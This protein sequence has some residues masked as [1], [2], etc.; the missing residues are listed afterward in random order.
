MLILMKFSIFALIKMKIIIQ[1]SFLINFLPSL[2]PLFLLLPLT[3]DWKRPE[4]MMIYV[5][6]I[7]EYL[8]LQKKYMNWCFFFTESA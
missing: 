2:P 5:F 7:T 8:T 6:L 1:L 4:Y 3:N